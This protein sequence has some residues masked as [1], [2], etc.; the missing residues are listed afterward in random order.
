MRLV[1]VECPPA[2]HNRTDEI[3]IKKMKKI[4]DIRKFFE[5]VNNELENATLEVTKIYALLNLLKAK[6]KVLGFCDEVL[7][8]CSSMQLTIH[9]AVEMLYIVSEKISIFE[10]TILNQNLQKKENEKSENS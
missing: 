4:E 3:K 5:D 2:N 6:Y 10:K 1:W 9:K 7:K 8:T